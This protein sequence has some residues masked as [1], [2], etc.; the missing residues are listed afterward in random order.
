MHRV[1]LAYGSSI[2][3]NLGLTVLGTNTLT[4]SGTNGY[5]GH[6]TISAGTLE[7]TVAR[8]LARL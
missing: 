6:T 1:V 2:N 4:L 3:G 7:A 8:R 5:T